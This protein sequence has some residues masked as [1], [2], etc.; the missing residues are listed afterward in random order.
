MLRTLWRYIW[1]VI[2]AMALLWVFFCVGLFLLLHAFELLTGSD[3]GALWYIAPPEGVTASV[4]H[5][6]DGVR[7]MVLGDETR[8]PLLFIHGGFG[9]FRH[10]RVMVH[11]LPL[12]ERYHLILVERPGYGGTPLPYMPDIMAEARLLL[13]VLEGKPHAVVAGHS[14]GAVLA[15]A[16]GLEAPEQI[17][18]IVNTAGLYYTVYNP[19]APVSI[20]PGWIAALLPR[21]LRTT[22][23]ENQAREYNMQPLEERYSELAV[24]LTLVWGGEDPMVSPLSSV[25]LLQALPEASSVVFPSLGH[26]IP[27]ENPAELTA[28]LLALPSAGAS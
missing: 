23:A 19:P 7:Y 15:I 3:R 18:Q 25:Q 6:A 21:V 10:G 22:F 5:T 28:I 17:A 13:P 14:Y 1:R 12:Y 20:L 16:M 2:K 27:Q 4:R 8:P 11:S 26:R 9:G 24:P